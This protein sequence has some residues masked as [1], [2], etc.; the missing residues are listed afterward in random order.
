ME[1]FGDERTQTRIG[2]CCRKYIGII[3]VMSIQEEEEGE[4]KREEEEGEGEGKREE[5]E[6]EG[7][8]KR[9][10]AEGEGEGKREEEAEGE[11]KGK[12]EEEEEGEGEGKREE[13]EA[14]GE[15]A[16]FVVEV[17][18]EEGSAQRVKT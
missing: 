3:T 12:R 18:R 7:E 13:A 4:G 15:W 17:E 2:Q 14:E 5:A 6:G 10:E 11:G 16:T 1:V 9:E 8:G